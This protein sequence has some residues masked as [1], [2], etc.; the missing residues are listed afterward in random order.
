MM[1]GTLHLLG[2]AYRWVHS[3]I[4]HQPRPSERLCPCDHCLS[5]TRDQ[6][7]RD[8][9]CPDQSRPGLRR[10]IS[11]PTPPVKIQSGD[12][13]PHSKIRTPVTV[14]SSDQIA[15]RHYG[16]LRLV[17]ALD[18]LR[19][20][21]I[22]SGTQSFRIIATTHPR[23]AWS[24]IQLCVSLGSQRLTNDTAQ[25]HAIRAIHPNGTTCAPA[26]A[27]ILATY[28]T[29]ENPKLRQVGALHRGFAGVSDG[30]ASGQSAKR[31][32][33]KRPTRD[34]AFYRCSSKIKSPLS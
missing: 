25:S 29:G 26:L 21:R 6:S 22:S 32:T 7:Q 2:G 30:L 27:F 8:D 9:M 10:P 12:K 23:H 1:A 11:R 20:L 24:E 18:F 4:S 16:V 33:R 31:P 13:S 14:H 28:P 34:R 5:D 17:G 19:A 15:D 3:S